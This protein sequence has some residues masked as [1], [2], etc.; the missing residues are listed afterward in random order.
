MNYNTEER[1]KNENT[2]E[3][4]DLKRFLRGASGQS[5]FHGILKCEIKNTRQFFP[6]YFIRN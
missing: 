3:D 4:E 5:K 1:N 2:D 6:E